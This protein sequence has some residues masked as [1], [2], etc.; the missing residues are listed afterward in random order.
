MAK[1]FIDNKINGAVLMCLN[2]DHMKEMGCAVLGEGCGLLMG[3]V[4]ILF[5]IGD[6][7]LFLDFLAL[8]KKHKRDADRSK[9]LWSATTPVLKCAYHRNCT[10]F[11]THVSYRV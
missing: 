9:S 2:E 3:V 11:L 5:I 1:A 6:R 8:L 7:I 10:S 4:I